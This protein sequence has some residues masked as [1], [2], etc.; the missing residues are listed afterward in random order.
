MML[1]MFVKTVL[2]MLTSAA[3]PLLGHIYH[4]VPKYWLLT[5]YKKKKKT[6]NICLNISELKVLFSN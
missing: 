1:A 3:A 2:T 5:N 4:K 6:Y